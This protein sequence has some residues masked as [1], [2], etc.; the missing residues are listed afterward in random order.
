M[1]KKPPAHLR[2]IDL[3]QSGSRRLERSFRGRAL[4]P[5]DRS[6]VEFALRDIGANHAVGARNRARR[7]P[8]NRS[9]HFD[10]G[11]RSACQGYRR[12]HACGE[13]IADQTNLLALNAA[14]EAAR[15]GAE[16]RG[17]AVVADEVRTLAAT[18]DKS[19][20]EVQSLTEAILS[21]VEEVGT[22]IKKVAETAKKD[23]K[24]AAGVAQSLE[25]R[26]VDMIEIAEGSQSIRLAAAEAERAAIEAQKGAEQVS[27]AAQEQSSGA[28][29]AQSAIEQQTTSLDQG[30]QAAQSL[31]VLAEKIR[32]GRATSAAV[33]Q[34][35]AS[36]ESF[37]RRSRKCR[38][39]QVR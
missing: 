7:G 2:T 37:P 4:E 24:S 23:A 8:S 18:S 21:E 29:E 31:A 20:R 12:D 1:P 34:I 3:A 38:A 15:A 22:L 28:T 9:R 6:A 39:R 27:T 32:S 16:G 33:E 17:F 11:S 5:A 25:A 26:L 36:A 30:Q 19:A 10:W 14:I 35:S 13:P